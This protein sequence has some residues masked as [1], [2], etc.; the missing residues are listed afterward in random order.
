MIKVLVN[1][2]GVIGK[3]VALAIHKQDDMELVGVSDAM[4]TGPIRT[5]LS[6]YGEL[7][8]TKLYCSAPQFYD[9]MKKDGNVSGLLEDLLKSGDVDVVVD[10]SP[11]GIDVKNKELYKKYNVKAIFQGGASADIADVSFNSFT[12]YDEAKGKQFVRVVS[13]N[14]T[15]LARTIG[16]LNKK[17][18]VENAFVTIVRRATDPPKVK[19]GPINAIVPDMKIPSH[20]GPDLKTVLHDVDVFT[21]AVKVPETLT[22]VHIVEATLKKEISKEELLNTF[23]ETPRINLIKATHGF[24]SNAELMEMMR[25]LGRPRY[26]MPEVAV[27]EELTSVRGNKVYWMHAIH[28]ESIVV[29]ESVDAIRA[30]FDLMPSEESIEKTNKAMGIM[31][32][33]I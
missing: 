24:G 33:D 23:R 19:I 7:H 14:T 26:D 18:G 22:H 21:M 10:A 16:S 15:G 30:M 31:K 13:C 6:P 11:K 1:G 12:N 28:S 4:I 5:L 3:R 27:W 9:S 32:F 25:D 20:H 2:M 8:G 17:Y 29:P